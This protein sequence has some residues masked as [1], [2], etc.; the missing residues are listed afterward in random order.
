MVQIKFEIQK[1]K[2]EY[3]KIVRTLSKEKIMA[4]VL[5]LI[6]LLQNEDVLIGKN[7]I[8][9]QKILADIDKKDFNYLRNLE[10]KLAV[11]L[12]DKYN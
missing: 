3:T 8:M 9:V 11:Y 10:E 12:P 7:K 4:R 6:N 2:D 1:Q 5:N